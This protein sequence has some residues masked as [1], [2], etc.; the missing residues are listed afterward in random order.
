MIDEGVCVCRGGGGGGGGAEGVTKE[1][2]S[3]ANTYMAHIA[4]GMHNEG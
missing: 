2:L 4:H 3:S 1:S